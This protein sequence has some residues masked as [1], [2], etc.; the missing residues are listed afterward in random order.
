MFALNKRLRLV[1]YSS[2]LSLFLFSLSEIDVWWRGVTWVYS[3]LI[4]NEEE[5]KTS[6]SSSTAVDIGQINQQGKLTICWFVFERDGKKFEELIHWNNV[7]QKK[8]KRS[9]DLLFDWSFAAQFIFDLVSTR[10][11]LFNIIWQSVVV[12]NKKNDDDQEEF[13]LSLES[14]QATKSSTHIEHSSEQELIVIIIIIKWSNVIKALK[15]E[16]F[17]WSRRARE[18]END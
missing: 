17:P 4:F 11:L 8:T 10:T 5:K 2:P 14:Q 13:M 1:S 16:K 15:E 9:V 12:L 6:S 18:R 3:L 7:N